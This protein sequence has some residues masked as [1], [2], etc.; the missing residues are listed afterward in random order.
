M[1]KKE[2]TARS[3]EISNLKDDTSSE[4]FNLTVTSEKSFSITV[5]ESGLNERVMHINN[6]FRGTSDKLESTTK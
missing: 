1:T 3:G 6:R 4:H 5:S 2:V